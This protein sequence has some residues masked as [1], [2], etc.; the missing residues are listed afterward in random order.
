MTATLYEWLLFLHVVAAMAWLGGTLVVSVLVAV[1]LRS[2]TP[3]DIARFVRSLRVVG[4]AVLAP[5]TILLPTL[6]IWMV[7]DSDAWD[8][9]QTWVWL[10]L[11][12]YAAAFVFGAG[13]QSRAAIG[14][15]RAAKAGDDGEAL[16]RLRAW[17]WGSRVIGVL[18]LVATW[19]M[20]FKPGL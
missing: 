8:F 17:S 18:L 10:G 12:L 13:F 6:G 20:V 14:A 2:A 5:A 7:V 4:P 15:E 3:E 16:R 1:V 19:D 9:G 11:A